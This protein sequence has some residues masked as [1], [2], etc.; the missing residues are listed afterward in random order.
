MKGSDFQRMEAAMEK[1]LS[2]QVWQLFL[3]VG[4]RRAESAGGSVLVRELRQV[5]EAFSG[6]DEEF[7]VDRL[8]DGEPVEVYEAWV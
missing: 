5:V 2:P 7:K 4:G 6:D 3:V 8:G 1:A